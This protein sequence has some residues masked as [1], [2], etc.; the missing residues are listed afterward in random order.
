MRRLLKLSP[1]ALLF[2]VLMLIP[3][4]EARAD[5][6]VITGGS[7]SIGGVPLSRNAWRALSYNVSGSNFSFT[8]G[9]LDGNSTHPPQSGCDRCQPG[10]AVSPNSVVVS[11]GTGAAVINGTPYHAW[12]FAGDT[13]MTFTGPSAIFPGD[14]SGASTITLTTDFSMTGTLVIHDIDQSGFPVVFTS[15]VTGQGT[16]VL[17]FQLTGLGAAQ[18]YYLSNIRYN[19]SQT[20]EPATLILLGTGLA[21]AAA[22]RKRRK[23]SR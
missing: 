13:V 21:G 10:T 4:A 6:L 3:S 23:A 1:A 14:S 22:Y 17:S 19:F 7:V 5:A 9:T 16:A 2:F 20:P 11:E 18:G 8:G 12:L 15:P